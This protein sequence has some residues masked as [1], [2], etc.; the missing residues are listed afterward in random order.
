MSVEALNIS[1]ND[2][3]EDI[4]KTAEEALDVFESISSDA[5][6]ELEGRTRGSAANALASINTLTGGNALRTVDASR[7]NVH[8]SLENLTKEPA[9]AR[10]L[11]RRDDGRIVTYYFC[12]HTPHRNPREGIH[13]AGRNTIIGRLASLPIGDE[14]ELQT[15]GGT[16]YLEIIERA[17]LRPKHDDQGWDSRDSILESTE[18]GPITVVSLRDLLED[19]A[20][21]QED[22]T[23]LARILAADEQSANVVDGIRRTVITKMGLRDQPILDKFQDEIFRLP[24]NSQLLLIGPPG[25]GKTTTLI[26]RLGQKLDQEYLDDDERN[27]INNAQIQNTLNHSESWMMFTPTPLLKQYLKEA[28]AREGIA[29]PDQKISTWIDFRRD[30]ARNRFR[31]LKSSSGNGSFIMKNDATTLDSDTIRKQISWY[32][33]F[34]D[35]QSAYFW[36]DLSDAADIILASDFSDIGKNLKES[37]NAAEKKTGLGSFLRI[38][39]LSS[40]IESVIDEKKSETDAI[41]D[42]TLNYQLNKDRSFLD[43]FGNFLDGLGSAEDDQDEQDGDDEEDLQPPKGR[44]ATVVAAYKRNIRSQARAKFSKKSIGKN[45]RSGKIAEWIKDRTP[46]EEELVNIGESLHLQF[47]LR[48]FN[49]PVRRYIDGMAG[50]YRKYRRACV[51]ENKWYASSATSSS[52]VDPLEVDMMLL[53]IMQ[54][55]SN[56][57]QDREIQR[58][59]DDP[60]YSTLQ[61]FRDITRNQIVVDEVTDF[62]PI[63]ISCMRL[64]SN[65]SIK[66]FFMCGDFNQRITEWGSRS[67]EEM[68]WSVPSVQIKPI[69]ISYRHSKQLNEFASEIVRLCEGEVIDISLPE[70]V[71]NDGFPPVIGTNLKNHNDITKWLAQRIIEIERSISPLPLPTVSILVNDESDVGPISSLLKSALIEENLNVV[72]CYEGQFSGQDNDIRVFDIQ[73]IK[74]L[75]FESV[76]F[77]GVDVLAAN[78][79]DLFDKF[80]YVG[81]TRAATYLGLTCESGFLPEKIRGLEK[82]CADSWNK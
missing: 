24:L 53:C 56:L 19:S 66:S 4:E 60:A 75:E 13:L 25:T 59:I 10:I 69:T 33:D 28:F 20:A 40:Q 7:D 34:S 72:P 37:I 49:K 27:L 78:K 45:S 2:Y 62:S 42:R 35:W 29:A 23:L 48:K 32:E 65:P 50:R 43:Q 3:S 52:D 22:L 11:A 58:L 63:Q 8:L 79:P 12:R 5:K 70:T 82:L 6:Q 36:Q 31:I 26:R 73:H 51:S 1:K 18:Y 16:I 39:K 21:G 30:I 14:Y 64:L 15:P 38:G 17:V 41:I 46:S 71:D 76:F 67:V 81:A 57:I 61:S 68:S 44:T 77:I 9:I 80:L 54:T 47:A 55:A 74:G